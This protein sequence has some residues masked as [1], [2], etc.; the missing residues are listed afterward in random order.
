MQ[1]PFCTHLC[2]H[3][4]N[5]V[6]IWA[7]VGPLS[8]LGDHPA[9][10]ASGRLRHPGWLAGLRTDK[11]AQLPGSL[12]GEGGT[13]HLQ[14]QPGSRGVAQGRGGAGSWPSE[15]GA[16]IFLHPSLPEP[17]WGAPSSLH[18]SLPKPGWAFSS[19][20]LKAWGLEIPFLLLMCKRLENTS[21]SR[22]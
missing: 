7:S 4:K 5:T 14:G 21:L 2:C 22:R 16:P 3:T 17:G 11:S 9:R 20:L 12:R 8:P 19:T 18:P 6:I 13:G 1:T 15:S 10:P